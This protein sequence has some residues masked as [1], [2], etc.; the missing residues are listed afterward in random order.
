MQLPSYARLLVKGL[1]QS[2]EKIFINVTVDE[3]LFK[4][5]D[6]PLIGKFCNHWYTKAL[7]EKYK[8]PKRIGLFFGVK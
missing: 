4:G 5:Y 1:I 3:L 8:I 6:E 7:C 2:F